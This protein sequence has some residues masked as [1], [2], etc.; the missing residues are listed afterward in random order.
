MAQRRA[1]NRSVALV[2]NE[3]AAQLVV[4]GRAEQLADDP[5]RIDRYRAHRIETARKGSELGAPPEG[6]AF[7][8]QLDDGDRGLLRIKPER[9][10]G[11]E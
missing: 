11:L 10:L 1:R 3:G 4:Y 8:Q 6:D 2:V 5:E 9:V 7:R